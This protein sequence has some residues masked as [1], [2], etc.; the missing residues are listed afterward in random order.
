MEEELSAI[1]YFAKRAGAA[2]GHFEI[3]Q[4]SWFSVVLGMSEQ[5]LS[6]FQVL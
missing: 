3:R 5:F 4:S 6:S 2:S 1:G